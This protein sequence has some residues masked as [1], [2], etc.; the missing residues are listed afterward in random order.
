MRLLVRHCR[1]VLSRNCATKDSEWSPQQV[2]PNQLEVRKVTSASYRVL[3]SKP[4]PLERRNYCMHESNGLRW[5]ATTYHFTMP[6]P[7]FHYLKECWLQTLGHCWC[8]Q[9]GPTMQVAW[10][11]KK[12]FSV[13]HDEC[14]WKAEKREY[15]DKVGSFECPTCWRFDEAHLS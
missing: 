3:N 1:S 4:F 14:V 5:L 10:V 7:S 9:E 15:R 6:R 2:M 12:V 11:E 13:G 8:D